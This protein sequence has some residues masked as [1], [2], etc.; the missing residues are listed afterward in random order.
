MPL[1]L[2]YLN[3]LLVAMDVPSRLL[4]FLSKDIMQFLIEGNDDFQDFES[5]KNN[6]FNDNKSYLAPFYNIQTHF[7]EDNSLDLISKLLSLLHFF[8]SISKTSINTFEQCLFTINYITSL[9]NCLMINNEVSAANLSGLL[10]EDYSLMLVFIFNLKDT[11]SPTELHN[12][13]SNH[14]IGNFKAVDIFYHLLKAI[15]YYRRLR[16]RI[17][18]VEPSKT[19]DGMIPLKPSE[20]KPEIVQISEGGTPTN[21]SDGTH[22][23]LDLLLFLLLDMFDS[24]LNVMCQGNNN[25]NN[26][27]N[28]NRS[29]EDK[30]ISDHLIFQSCELCI[31]LVEFF[32]PLHSK[33]IITLSY[34]ILYQL[35]ALNSRVL[36][37]EFLRNGIAILLYGLFTSETLLNRDPLTYGLMLLHNIV[38]A[39]PDSLEYIVSSKIF[40]N[41]SHHAKRLYRDL[42]FV[43]Y[44]LKLA[45]YLTS[46]SPEYSSSAMDISQ[47]INIL[48]L[49]FDHFTDNPD[50]LKL[51]I[52]AIGNIAVNIP[53]AEEIAD[54]PNLCSLFIQTLSNNIQDG[55]LLSAIFLTLANL[56]KVTRFPINLWTNNLAAVLLNAT[57]IQSENKNSI[58]AL[59]LMLGNLAAVSAQSRTFIKSCN[60]I[61]EVCRLLK[62]H[63]AAYFPQLV[64]N[65]CVIIANMSADDDCKIKFGNI[66]VC[67]ILSDILKLYISYPNVVEQCCIAITNLAGNNVNNCINL[68]YFDTP[69]YLFDCLNTYAEN[70]IVLEEILS[71]IACITSNGKN[72]KNHRKFYLTGICGENNTTDE[73]SPKNSILSSIVFK[74]SQQSTVSYTLEQT[75]RV[76]AN[77]AVDDSCRN[78]LGVS[79]TCEA[80]STWAR[81]HYSNACSKTNNNKSWSAS[82]NNNFK[83]NFSMLD[84]DELSLNSIF[85]KSSKSF[86]SVSDNINRLLDQNSAV[87]LELACTAIYNLS[88]NSQSNKFIFSK[89]KIHTI[90]RIIL[91]DDYHQ[92]VFSPIKTAD[93]NAS[94]DTYVK[95]DQLISLLRS[96]YNI[97]KSGSI[98]TSDYESPMF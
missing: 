32:H 13:V 48:I 24:I 8:Y 54:V 85:A 76:I 73:N 19:L 78:L 52:I 66:G 39:C 42:N 21:L 35:S 15:L 86:S 37:F 40:F 60:L 71:A 88:C 36:C 97:I 20:S 96:T 72:S 17:I 62:F 92:Q 83:S 94:Q 6:I 77:L 44:F 3:K 57:T 12:L 70:S 26:N 14:L 89:F 22:I 80:I 4:T 31:E 64:E 84:D 79:G 9:L 29:I 53:H 82:E 5:E 93:L 34:R 50:I 75:F 49:I 74:S 33:K 58:N 68:G 28:N 38:E 16:D 98:S 59:L 27:N 25:N 1:S 23:D 56:S 46:I 90:L 95:L 43:E 65:G 67:E 30:I 91:R 81:Q 45:V 61:D 69:K 10:I 2:D 47:I 55:H 63:M 7:I 41:I 11:T 18:V 51:S 87:L